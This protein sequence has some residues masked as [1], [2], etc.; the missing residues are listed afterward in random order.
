MGR[1]LSA[2]EK[3]LYQRLDEVMHY[4]W[5]P[6]GVSGVPQARDEYDAYLPQVFGMLLESKGPDEISN[7]LLKVEDERMG[8][9][10]SIKKAKEV[11]DVLLDWT[12]A[13]R[14]KHPS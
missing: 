9:T 10:P 2:F 11:A 3:E 4:V 12:E 6:I 13:L 5:D 7:Y 8:L 1:K 14:R